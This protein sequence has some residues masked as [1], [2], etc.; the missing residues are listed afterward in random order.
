[1]PAQLSDAWSARDHLAARVLPMSKEDISTI[2]RSLTRR[3]NGF[4]ASCKND[5]SVPWRTRVERD[6]MRIL[7][8]DHSVVS[9]KAMS[10]KVELVLDGKRHWVVPAVQ[11]VTIQGPMV[12]DV[13]K[14]NEAP[15][16]TRAAVVDA[17]R[18]IYANLN[19]RYCCLKPGVVRMEPRLGNVAY[20]R[21]YK[22]IEP[23][24]ASRLRILELVSTAQSTWTVAG[25]KDALGEEADGLFHMAMCRTLRL[26]LSAPRADRHARFVGRLGIGRAQFHRRHATDPHPAE[27]A[28]PV[29]VPGARIPGSGW[30][31]AAPTPVR[32]RRERPRTHDGQGVRRAADGRSVG[33]CHP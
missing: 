20:A 4:I 15:G 8:L 14:A 32:G 24:P 9:Y 21:S 12:F 3:S 33:A 10:E 16:R 5:A 23:N 22:Q 17:L 1:M 29:R 28:I 13:F 11:A 19:T 2:T 18:D 7:E 30:R 31:Q 26:D 27:R 6:L 25:L